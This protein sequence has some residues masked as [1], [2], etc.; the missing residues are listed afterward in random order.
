[1]LGI[2]FIIVA[3]I[4][5]YRTARNNGH[6]PLIWTIA[7]VAGFFLIQFGVAVAA[8]LY[9]GIG[10]GA[11]G[12]P[13]DTYEKFGMVIGLIAIVPSVA[14]VLLIL[15]SVNRVKEGSPPPSSPS[16]SIFDRQDPS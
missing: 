15:R 10:I 8:G 7:A 1:M 11:W 13:E 4:F 2:I 9:I 6:K 5:V 16:M 12:W 14:F 3:A